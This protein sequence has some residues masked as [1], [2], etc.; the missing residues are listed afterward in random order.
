MTGEALA[1][2]AVHTRA[3]IAYRTCYVT[4]VARTAPSVKASE[5][6]RAAG[7]TTEG[8][9]R[10]MRRGRRL[11]PDGGEVVRESSGGRTADRWHGE[12]SFRLTTAGSSVESVVRRR[13]GVPTAGRP[14]ISRGGR[15]THPF[16]SDR[17]QVSRT[18]VGNRCPFRGRR[19]VRRVGSR[20]RETTPSGRARGRRVV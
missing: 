5:A 19:D 13:P 11:K 3:A 20:A 16:A 15:S 2:A 8:I 9:P 17:L 1:A 6:R 18:L 7:P 12:A 14:T 10:T 4:V